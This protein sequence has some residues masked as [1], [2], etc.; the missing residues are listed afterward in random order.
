M[1]K[2]LYSL[3]EQHGQATE[4]LNSMDKQQARLEHPEEDTLPLH[5]LLEMFLVES[6]YARDQLEQLVSYIPTRM[7]IQLARTWVPFRTLLTKWMEHQHEIQHNQEAD[8]MRRLM[9]TSPHHAGQEVYAQFLN[10]KESC[11]TYYLSTQL[12]RLLNLLRDCWTTITSKVEEDA[13]LQQYL[14]SP[15]TPPSNYHTSTSFTDCSWTNGQCRCSI[16]AGIN[17]RPN[18]SSIWS[19]DVT[20]WDYYHLIYYLFTDPRRLYCL[21]V[22]G[23]DWITR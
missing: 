3:T 19:A 12:N 13:K 8:L 7:P 10:D 15:S 11:T 14:P 9:V 5:L 6:T 1:Y 16:F 23:T 22:D 21:E 18:Q 4:L 17:K 20:D 2:Q